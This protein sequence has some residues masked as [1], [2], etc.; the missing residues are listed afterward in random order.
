MP[1]VSVVIPVLNGE[2]FI[3]DAV[4]SVLSQSFKDLELIVVDDGSTDGTG[5][6]VK[7]FG[8]QLV[9]R[10]QPNAGADRAYNQGI[11]MTS[12]QYVAFLDHDDLWYPDKIETQVAILDRLPEVGLTFSEVDDVDELGNPIKKKTWAGRRGIKDDLIGDFRAILKRRFPIA[13]PSA[14]MIRRDVLGKIGGFDPDLPPNGHGD[15][16]MCVLAGEISKVYFMIRPLAQYRVHKWQM[17]HERRDEIHANFIILL[18][19]LWNRWRDYPEYR[20]L[21]IPL[22]GRYWTKRGREALKKHDVENAQRY[23]ALSLKFRP[24]YIRCWLGL[25][26]LQ[27]YKMFLGGHQRIF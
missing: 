20:A 13:V 3:T 6:I 1:K 18:D 8:S 16:E 24:F 19:T 23:L 10:Y 11:S 5:E 15:V 26:R 17:T 7:S 12:G 14:M 4:E 2:R 25:L 22:Y 21:L 9:Y 27:I